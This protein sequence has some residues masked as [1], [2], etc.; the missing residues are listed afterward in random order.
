MGYVVDLV[1]NQAMTISEI[2]AVLPAAIDRVQNGEE[3][4][5]TRHGQNV[6]VLVQPQKWYG[7]RSGGVFER[8]GS[9]AKRL[10]DA[11]KKPLQV[12]EVISQE[13]GEEL[14]GW[15]REGR[16]RDRV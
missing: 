16:D 9:L 8:A 7:R 2:R 1:W 13:R 12:S 3:V 15:V 14:I 5:I 10:E 6:A 11:K 4:F